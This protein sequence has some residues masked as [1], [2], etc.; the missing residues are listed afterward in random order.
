MLK[1]VGLLLV[2][3]I[4]WIGIILGATKVFAGEERHVMRD[5]N[6]ILIKICKNGR[7]DI[8]ATVDCD[9][10]QYKYGNEALKSS[11]CYYPVTT[12]EQV[13]FWSK[14]MDDNFEEGMR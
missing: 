8:Y 11:S 1:F 6:P 13:K 4:M 14:I 10:V 5:I 12:N 7:C 2:G 9:Y 3:A